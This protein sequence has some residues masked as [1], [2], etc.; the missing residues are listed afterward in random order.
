LC[1]IA[2]GKEIFESAGYTGIITSHDGSTWTQAATN[3]TG[4]LYNII[5]GNEMF[6]AV[7][8]NG[9]FT[10][11]DGFNWELRSLGE[12]SKIIYGYYNFIAL[13]STNIIN[14]SDG[15]TWRDELSG[16]TW[17]G[18][19]YGN[20]LY[21][22]VG[23]NPT[24]ILIS[25]DCYNWT[26]QTINFSS[27]L[28]KVL[29]AENEDNMF[30]IIGAGKIF[31]FTINIVISIAGLSDLTAVNNKIDNLTT[32]K[33]THLA[34]VNSTPENLSTC[35]ENLKIFTRPAVEPID[36]HPEKI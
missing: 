27:P 8:A 33:L 29:F 19:A 13:Q 18:I 21:V 34:Q 24:T 9:I 2:Y 28:N 5:Y 23:N 32:L 31:A 4:F 7:G 22:P 14:S 1:G 6:V 12:V 15:I 17:Y 11:Q 26:K 35:I 3:T 25:D 36:K 20:H 16:A 10:G 30:V